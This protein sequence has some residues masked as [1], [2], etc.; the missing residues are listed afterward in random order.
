MIGSIIGESPLLAAVLGAV[1]AVFVF[2]VAA[3][4]ISSWRARGLQ[5]RPPVAARHE[6]IFE[7]AP[8]EALEPPDSVAPPV[9]ERILDA[10]R[11]RRRFGAGAVTLSF[12]LGMVVGVGTLAFYMSDRFG[13]AVEMLTALIPA[14]PSD[15]A[16][17]AAD[18]DASLG[19]AFAADDPPPLPAVSVPKP[20]DPTV[21]ESAS[22]VEKR[23]AAFA[24]KLKESLPRE[25]GPELSLISVESNGMTLSLGYA[26][27]REL[28]EVEIHAFDAYI[29]RTVKSL[30]CGQSAREIRFLNDNGV[31]FHMAYSDPK[32]ATVARLTV[33]PGYCA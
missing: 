4:L 14:S 19:T 6:P 29:M 7:L 2:L 28:G 33:P 25:A 15:A 26:V 23:M 24:R 3:A 17:K 10:P 20:G 18:A 27:G 12:L 13:P 5:E 21:D 22:D 16:Q 30:F 1:L 8:V 9:D 32:G 31:A 11:H